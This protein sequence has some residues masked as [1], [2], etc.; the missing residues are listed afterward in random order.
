MEEKLH[1]RHEH[2]ESRHGTSSLRPRGAKGE[3]NDRSEGR[4]DI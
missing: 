4:A 2:R 3:C 1:S